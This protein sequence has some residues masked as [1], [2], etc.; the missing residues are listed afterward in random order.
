ME[1]QI[2]PLEKYRMKN[3]YN[4][5]KFL[6]GCKQKRFITKIFLFEYKFVLIEWKYILILYKYILLNRNL[7][8]LNKIIFI[9]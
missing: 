5:K 1:E 7:F 8:W 3:S 4:Q 6:I 2:W 9:T